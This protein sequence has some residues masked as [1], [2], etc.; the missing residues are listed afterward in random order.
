MQEDAL[1]AIC[2]LPNDWHG[3]GTVS[4]RVLE[5]IA[6]YCEGGLSHSVETGT[7]RTT[8]L[9]SHL[10]RD[11]TVF[12]KQ[13]R[14]D[15]DSFDRV[16]ASPLFV[17]DAVRFVEG[18]TQITVPRHEFTDQLDFAMLDGPHGF[19]F[20][21]VEY[22]YIYPHVAPNGLLIVDDIQIRSIKVMLDI[23]REDSMW[24][25]VEVVGQTAFLRRTDAPT[26]D[27]LGDGW[28]L[29]GYNRRRRRLRDLAPGW[30]KKIWHRLH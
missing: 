13:D 30:T 14:G 5:A 20:P 2:A 19:P 26:L 4:N 8:L 21:F 7:G 23:I 22:C 9:I 25:L 16:H 3:A 17:P 10:S 12:A 24:N 29:Q 6:R 11:H 18:P 27:P 1:A 15:G 28:W